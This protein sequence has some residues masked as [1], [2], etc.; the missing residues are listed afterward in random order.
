MIS[1]SPLGD[2]AALRRLKAMRDTVR[3]GMAR[4]VIKLGSD[5]KNSVRQKLSDSVVQTLS[6]PLMRS[7][8]RRIDRRNARVS[9]IA[10]GHFNAAARDCGSS[11]RMD[12]RTSLRQTKEAFRYPVNTNEVGVGAFSRQMQIY[13]RRALGDMAPDIRTS[14]KDA[15]RQA[16]GK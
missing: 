2:T 12:L 3:R 5:L 7:T 6:G 4:T 10:R 15:L 9:A 1:L 16:L 11:G 14:I 8:A 13:P